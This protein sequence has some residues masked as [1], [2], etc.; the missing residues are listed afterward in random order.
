MGNLD[1]VERE[2]RSLGPVVALHRTSAAVGDGHKFVASQRSPAGHQEEG[3]DSLKLES[4]NRL[5]DCMTLY[6]DG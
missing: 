5:G 1:S 2:M 6:K 4:R 3:A